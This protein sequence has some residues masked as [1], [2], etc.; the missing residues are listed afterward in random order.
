MKKILKERKMNVFCSVVYAKKQFQ[1]LMSVILLLLFF[2]GVPYRLYPQGSNIKF[3]RISIEEG[4]S[5]V[6][7][8]AILQD[9]KGFMWFGT[10]DGLNKYDGYGFTVYKRDPSDPNS[11]SDNFIQSIYEDK[12]GTL[13]IVLLNKGLNTFDLKTE[14]FS[15]YVHN[16]ANSNSLSN[17]NVNPRAICEDAD[18]NMWVGTFG[19]GINKFDRTEGQ[20]TRYMNDISDVNSL[21]HN[22]IS[23]IYKDQS[24]T[25]WIGTFGG[26]LNRLVPSDVEGFDKKNNTFIHYTNDPGNFAGISHNVVTG[27]YR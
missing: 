19:G 24:G 8:N 27:L 10:Q 4:L 13:W 12:T 14:Q 25:L 20:F 21:S 1:F 17:D 22:N 3:D 6:S 5:Q 26:G 7:I 23:F 15:R 18:G 2:L 9:S 16:P 11:L